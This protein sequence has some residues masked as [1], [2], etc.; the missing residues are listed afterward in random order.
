MRAASPSAEHGS[1]CA[2]AA[3]RDCRVSAMV[4]LGPVFTAEALVSIWA[5]RR[6]LQ[7][8][9]AVFRDASL[10][11]QVSHEQVSDE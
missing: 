4:A 3:A 7:E 6:L 2:I 8:Y 9:R 5:V 10:D 1:R 11:E